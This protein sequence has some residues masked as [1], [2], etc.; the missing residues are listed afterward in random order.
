[1]S[2]RLLTLAA[3]ATAAFAS[4]VHD[5]AYYE[6]KFFNWLSEFKVQATSGD[7]FA[8]MIQNF[9]NNEDAIAAHNAKNLSW[10]MGHN[11]FSHMTAEE[12]SAYVRLGLKKPEN[13][14][15][16]PQE[17]STEAN[18]AT[19]DW[20]N[21]GAVTA[22]KDQ[23]SCG[24]CW[25]FSTTGAIEGAHKIAKGSL[26]SY[27]EQ[28]LVDCDKTNGACNGG[29]M[30]DAFTWIKKN[31]GICTESAYPYQGVE[32]TCKTS[33]SKDATAA[34]KSFTDVKAKDAA[35]F[36]T[37]VAKQPVAVAIEANTQLQLYKSGVFSATCGDSLNHGVL[38]VGY[39]SDAWIVKNSWGP[40]WGESGYIRLSRSAGGKSGQCGIYTAASY[41]NL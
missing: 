20:R 14:P 27:S 34:P 37:A 30:D 3:I 13:E 21:S 1:M 11:Q 2:A 15:G 17:L 24:S 22:V 33:C 5:R 6:E 25:A 4:N 28:Q 29:W 12:W 26:V 16:L 19:V 18:P 32:Q 9:A 31:G 10:T 35:A 23:K 40:T 39:T 41:P 36:E 7:H 38:A 8:K